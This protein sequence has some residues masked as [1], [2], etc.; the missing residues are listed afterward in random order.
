M[1]KHPGQKQQD[2]KKIIAAELE[3]GGVVELF[4][5]VE[6]KRYQEDDTEEVGV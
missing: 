4:G 2:V 5:D 1:E 6:G 3:D